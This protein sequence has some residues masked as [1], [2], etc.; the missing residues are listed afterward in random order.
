[1]SFRRVFKSLASDQRAF[2]YDS[3]YFNYRTGTVLSDHFRVFETYGHGLTA[4]SPDCAI[5]P[6][7]FTDYLRSLAVAMRSDPELA[8]NASF[9]FSGP[10]L[11]DI[12]FAQTVKYKEP[13]DEGKTRYRRAP[14]GYY[15]L[16][17]KKIGNRDT[18]EHDRRYEKID[19][20]MDGSYDAVCRLFWKDW[21]SFFRTYCFTNA[22]RDWFGEHQNCYPELPAIPGAGND[23][24]AAAHDVRREAHD[25]FNVCLR[26]I[27]ATRLLDSTDCTLTRWQEKPE[28]EKAE[29]STD[30]A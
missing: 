11:K 12:E 5:P 17:E 15:S 19:Q 24:I 27:E 10:S 20:W 9:E 14:S 30:A 1:M 13:K 16:E 26:I 22:I 4:H 2:A 3:D 8:K 7:Y 29:E 6:E 25:A 21:H 28:V 23:A 18:L